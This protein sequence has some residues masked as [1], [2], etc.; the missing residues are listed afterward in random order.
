MYSRGSSAYQLEMP[1]NPVVKVNRKVR[2]RNKRNAKT[3]ATILL[4]L[5][6]CL[7][8][9]YRYAAIYG[10]SVD[11][12]KKM[13]E[14][15][16]VEAKNM[17]LVMEIE[18]SVDLKKIEEYAINELGMVRPQRYQIRYVTPQVEDKMEKTEIAQ[19]NIWE[20]LQ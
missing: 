9:C 17:Q 16:D 13:S 19:K 7:F 4:G 20:Y 14:L 6:V 10:Q 3:V 18:K 15:R 11:Y 2:A 12:S 5:V 8:M 1:Y